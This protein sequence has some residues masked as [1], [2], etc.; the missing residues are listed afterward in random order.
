M[1][2]NIYK[3]K[4][5]FVIRNILDEYII[6]PVGEQAVNDTYIMSVNESGFL[7]WELLTEGTTAEALLEKMLEEY[8]IDEETAKSDI[9]TFINLLT[10]RNI[11][12]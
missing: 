3:I 6:V 1:S 8:E 9:D 7:L 10:D 12:E 4:E 11:L 2:D 5:G